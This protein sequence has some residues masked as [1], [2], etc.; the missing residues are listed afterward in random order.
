M[1]DAQ[2]DCPIK[3]SQIDRATFNTKAE[4][5]LL[6]LVTNPKEPVQQ[7]HLHSLLEYLQPQDQASGTPATVMELARC[8]VVE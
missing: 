4:C 7:I 1:I 8:K 6:T 5:Y 3:M 2:T